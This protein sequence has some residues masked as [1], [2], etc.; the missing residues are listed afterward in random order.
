MVLSRLCGS[1]FASGGVAHEKASRT[2]GTRSRPGQ[3]VQTPPVP[4]Q[5]SAPRAGTPPA[6]PS[7]LGVFWAP[8]GRGAGCWSLGQK[9][10]ARAV[11][12]FTSRGALVMLEGFAGA[13]EAALS[14]G[15]HTANLPPHVQNRRQMRSLHQKSFLKNHERRIAV[16]AGAARWV[17]RAQT[18]G[19]C[20]SLSPPPHSQK[21]AC[22]APTACSTVPSDHPIPPTYTLPA[23]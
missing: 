19:W 23:V 4:A 17:L 20:S 11:E 16:A 8:G 7:S 13:E 10:S 6:S 12:T 15:T 5:S 14:R 9:G 3:G 22:A 21:I 2:G 18:L 1:P